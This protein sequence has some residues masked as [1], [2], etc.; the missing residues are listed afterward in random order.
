MVG[1]ATTE[2]ATAVENGVSERGLKE[3][4]FDAVIPPYDDGEAMTWSDG[5]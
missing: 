4:E 1:L 3:S 5:N 2:P